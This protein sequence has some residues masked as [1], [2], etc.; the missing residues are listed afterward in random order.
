MALTKTEE[1]G[2]VTVLAAGPLQ[3]RLDTVV[4]DGDVELARTYHRVV[5]LPSRQ[6]QTVPA[7]VLRRIARVVWTEEVVAAWEAHHPPGGVE[8]SPV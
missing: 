8:G 7:G 4:R 1:L 2:T 6:L 3:V 5:Y